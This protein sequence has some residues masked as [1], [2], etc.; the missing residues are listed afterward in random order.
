L[1]INNESTFF[2][3]GVA[4][5]TASPR[6]T[7]LTITGNSSSMGG[8]F[9]CNDYADS[10][11]FNSIIY[12]NYTFDSI[13]SQ[14]WIWDVYSEP[15]FYHCDIQYGTD[16]FGGSTFHGIYEN[17]IESD[18]VFS[19]ISDN[20][21]RLKMESPCI[22]SGT[23]DT[24]G[25][26]LPAFDFDFHERILYDRIDIGAFEYDGPVGQTE[27]LA[28]EKLF[29]LFPNPVSENSV[30]VLNPDN[31]EPVHFELFDISGRSISIFTPSYPGNSNIP[32]SCLKINN[33]IPGVYFM[34]AICKDRI[35]V[36]RI[37]KN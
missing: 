13:G 28:Q 26:M 15:E 32:V 12:G 7:N 19:D 2:G 1:I 30:I 37:I 29:I 6:M 4:C 5:L 33:F 21:F 14:V 20:N 27:H 35:T 23:P 10:Q 8:G 25:L 34:K 18:P 36:T 31:P 11:L 17:C 9:Y 24:T 16:S 22:N 3:G